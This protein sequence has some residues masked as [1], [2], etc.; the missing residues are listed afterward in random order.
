MKLTSTLAG[1]SLALALTLSAQAQDLLTGADTDAILTAAKVLGT[2][3]LHTQPNGDPLIDATTNG[4]AYQIYFKNCTAHAACEDLNFYVGFQIQPGLD[5]IN[6]WNRDKRFSRAYL[7]ERGDA[8][9]EMDLDLVQGVT[10]NYLSS[11]L[12][13]WEQVVA[14]FAMYIGYP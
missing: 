1:S 3:E 12:A 8:V 10:P 4:T 7:D 14:E 5:D 2:A 6:A 9:V 11:Q 13:L